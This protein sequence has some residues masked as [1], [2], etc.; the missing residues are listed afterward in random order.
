MKKVLICLT[1]IIL[2][3]S[4]KDQRLIDKIPPTIDPF[5][6]SWDRIRVPDGGTALAV[7][8]SIDDTL[9]VTT[10]YH[11][12]M[13]TNKGKNVTRSNTKIYTTPGL[14]AVQD[15]IYA[16]AG[17]GYDQITKTKFAGFP[18]NYTLDKGLTW[19]YFT[20]KPS[21]S[22][23]DIGRVTTRDDVTYELEY[24]TGPDQNGQGNS[25][26]HQTTINR[27][28]NGVKSPFKHPVKDADPSNLYLDSK[29][30]LYITSGDTVHTTGVV[31]G[32]PASAPAY[33]YISKVPIGQ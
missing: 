14:A 7:I 8:G 25:Y 19:H 31:I 9:L 30:R 3:A 26:I 6:S 4:C 5:D 10:M 16:F 32:K 12:Y 22:Q 15:T 11:T 23:V 21:I 17:Q 28:V 2:A 13:V 20:V 1:F 33:V 18:N 24:H 29:E 27:I